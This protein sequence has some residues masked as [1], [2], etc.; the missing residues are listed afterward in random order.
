MDQQGAALRSHDPSGS[1]DAAFRTLSGLRIA[2]YDRLAVVAPAGVPAYRRGDLLE[3]LVRDVDATQDLPLR[4]V[5]P[6]AA[7]GTVAVGSVVALLVDRATARRARTVQADRIDVRVSGQE[8]DAGAA[9]ER[10]S[11]QS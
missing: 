5:L 7:G 6:Y 8:G 4:V 10:P 11:I 3:R 2:V 9:D 1:H